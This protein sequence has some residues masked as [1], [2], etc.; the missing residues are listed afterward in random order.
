[1]TAPRRHSDYVETDT[2]EWDRP[3]KLPPFRKGAVL[4]Y[5]G[6]DTARYGR[7]AVGLVV[8]A[9]SGMQGSMEVITNIRGDVMYED[10]AET[11]PFRIRTVD[12]FSKVQVGS[13]Y[14]SVTGENAYEWEL[15]KHTA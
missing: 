5:I 15:L 3:A 1:M 12:G 2:I 6:K 7:N 13:E 9:F 4:R 10:E 11:I 8:L 14:V